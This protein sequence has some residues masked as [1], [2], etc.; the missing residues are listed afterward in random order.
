MRLHR[1]KKHINGK[2]S[3]A[4][5]MAR[6][7]FRVA[8]GMISIPC[9][10]ACNA[11]TC[12]A[13]MSLSDQPRFHVPTR[14]FISPIYFSPRLTY[15]RQHRRFRLWPFLSVFSDSQLARKLSRYPSPSVSHEHATATEPAFAYG[16]THAELN[17]P[18]LADTGSCDR[19]LIARNL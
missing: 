7:M 10:A 15:S 12:Y 16:I 4:F 5:I 6:T 19:P 8:F 18:R 17:S 2:V 3:D 14:R 13:T 9:R 1:D 11:I